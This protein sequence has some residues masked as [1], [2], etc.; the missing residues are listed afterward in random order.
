MSIENDEILDVLERVG[1]QA[2]PFIQGS[3]GCDDECYVC[4]LIARI[5]EE[6]RE[7]RDGRGVQD[8]I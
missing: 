8:E 6:I 3:G 5:K 4:D 7:A 1:C 2:P